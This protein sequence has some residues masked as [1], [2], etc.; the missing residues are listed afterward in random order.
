VGTA[1]VGALGPAESQP[2]E[3]FDHGLDELRA[4]ALGIEIFVAEDE[5]AVAVAGTL[6]GNRE[7]VGVADVE[8]AGGGGS[9]AAAV[10][11]W[12]RIRHNNLDRV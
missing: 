10:A 7:G 6:S 5:G 2:V 4:G 9:E 1:A 8:Q 11:S 3:V 12:W